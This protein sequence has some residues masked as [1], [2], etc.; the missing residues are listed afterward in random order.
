MKNKFWLI[1]LL[2]LPIIL[3]LI[4]GFSLLPKEVVIED[5]IVKS[6]IITEFYK[7]KNSRSSKIPMYVVIDNERFYVTSGVKWAAKYDELLDVLT[8]GNE[9][10]IEYIT[11]N[12]NN[13]IVSIKV[14]DS[15]CVTKDETCTGQYEYLALKSTIIIFGTYLYFLFIFFFIILDTKFDFDEFD[16]FSSKVYLSKLQI[17]INIL[18]IVCLIIGSIFLIIINKWLYFPCVTII[19]GY[20]YWTKISPVRLYFGSYGFNIIKKCKKKHY[21]WN[22]VK[23][24]ISVRKRFRTIII[25][26]FKESYKYKN[27]NI[28]EYMNIVKHN[29]NK[30]C[31]KFCLNNQKLLKFNE[32]CKKYYLKKSK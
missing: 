9:I 14:D 17:I 31:Y 23:E 12:K 1:C 21:G 32:L 13:S 18:I 19:V 11:Q 26:N 8:V 5:T 10:E 24:I 27:T 22:A 20:I 16:I 2:V 7:G 28:S 4:I 15:Y 3:L 25:I 6:G 29:K 30:Y